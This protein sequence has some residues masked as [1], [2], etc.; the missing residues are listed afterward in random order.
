MTGA[1]ASAEPLVLLTDFAS[2]ADELQARIWRDGTVYSRYQLQY[3]AANLLP[4]F[5]VATS[6]MKA[7]IPNKQPEVWIDNETGHAHA[8]GLA[9][10]GSA[11]VCPVCAAKISLERRKEIEQAMELAEEMGWRVLFVTLTAR[12]SRDDQLDDLLE[13]FKAAKRYMRSGRKW[14]EVKDDYM[15]KGSITA[16]ENTWGF[17]NGWHVHF[18]EIFFV[19]AAVDLE[20]VESRFYQL[21][22]KSL[23]REGLDCSRDHG[24]EVLY[25]ADKVGKYITKWG[26]D[27]ELTSI[28]K[29]A[30]KGHFTPFQ[31]LALYR[32]G[33]EWAGGLFQ[34]HAD[35]TKGKTS[36]RW[37]R[38]LRDD[39]GLGRELTDEEL[40]EAGAG[41][42]S[43][44]MVRFT[45][46]EWNQLLYSG[47]QGVIGELLII[48]ERGRKALIIWLAEYFDIHPDEPP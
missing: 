38:G 6:C 32:E 20:E 46:S 45:R 47:R 34:S 4:G 44:L 26:L 42:D 48:A 37:S 24:V 15:V 35:A 36:L 2:G 40:A 31:L 22:H 13:S 30:K 28:H 9:R 39:M 16:T 23:D 17:D 21:W 27:N 12:H 1:A 14:Q 29:A 41:D 19:G 43:H 3:T 8:H 5:R 33:H 7:A 18:H 10:C 11:W 25:G